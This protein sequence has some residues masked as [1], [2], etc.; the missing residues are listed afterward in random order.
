MKLNGPEQRVVEVVAHAVGVDDAVEH[1][2]RGRVDPALLVDR[3]VDQRTRLLVEHRVRRHAVDLG[4]RGED[5]PL[6]VLHALA[7]D[8]EVG[9]E[10]ELEHAQRMRHVLRRVGDRDER[11]HH[12]ALLDVVLDPLLVD[13]DIAFHEVEAIVLRQITELVVG[14]VDAVDLPVAD[15]AGSQS[16]SA[17][18][19]KPFAPRIMIFSA[20]SS[21]ADGRGKLCRPLLRGAP[22]NRSC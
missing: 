1:L 21:P 7:H 17:L 4:G 8:V 2:L 14:E 5:Q 16:V 6:V 22:S 18:P 13:G 10:V 11:H 3:T 9:L 12:V 20:I 19:M 15:C